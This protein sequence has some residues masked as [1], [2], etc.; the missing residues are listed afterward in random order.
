MGFLLSC[1]WYDF[2]GLSCEFIAFSLTAFAAGIAFGDINFFFDPA[3]T[4]PELNDSRF[5]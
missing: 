1:F 5:L 4:L 3:S 2:N